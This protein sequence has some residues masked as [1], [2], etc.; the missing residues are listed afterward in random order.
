MKKYNILIFFVIIFLFLSCEKENQY[1]WGEA[2]ALKNGEEWSAVVHAELN[3]YYPEKIDIIIDVLDKNKLETEGLNLRKVF[4]A[5]GLY[6]VSNSNSNEKP[7]SIGS[8]FYTSIGGDVTSNSYHVDEQG[9]SFV[10]ITNYNSRTKII[11]GNFQIT[12]II[13]EPRSPWVENP[14]DTIHFTHGYFKTKVR[15]LNE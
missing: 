15:M 2:T 8:S 6:D 14:A 9:N 10:K 5:E 1:Y 13:T 4:M 11:E 7:D 12:Y 3:K